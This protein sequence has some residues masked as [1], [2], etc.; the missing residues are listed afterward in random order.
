MSTLA[1][2][3]I[4]KRAITIQMGFASSSMKIEYGCKHIVY[5]VNGDP[6]YHTCPYCYVERRLSEPR[7]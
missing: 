7:T 1:W 3:E 6:V 4:E 2:H 5:C